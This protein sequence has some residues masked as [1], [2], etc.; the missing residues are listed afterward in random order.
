M[1]FSR[2]KFKAQNCFFYL[3]L[4]SE[5]QTR[6]M[7]AKI[8]RNLKRRPACKARNFSGSFTFSKKKLLGTFFPFWCHCHP[9]PAFVEDEAK[10]NFSLTWTFPKE[11]SQRLNKLRLD[12]DLF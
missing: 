4:V 3:R 2:E 8:I 5:L 12:S 7:N 6:N 9:S 11:P 10:L 1:R